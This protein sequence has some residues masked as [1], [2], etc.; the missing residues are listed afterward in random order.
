MPPGASTQ[1]LQPLLPGPARISCLG[2]RPPFAR[3]VN[4]RMAKGEYAAAKGVCP[5][6]ACSLTRSLVRRCPQTR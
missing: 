2:S 4:V 6:A 3:R 1:I 5:N